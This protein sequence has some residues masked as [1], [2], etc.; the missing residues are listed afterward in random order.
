M[1]KGHTE[2]LQRRLAEIAACLST[3]EQMLANLR[4]ASSWDFLTEDLDV[5]REELIA[6][7]EAR[8]ARDERLQDTLGQ[9]LVG[10]A[11]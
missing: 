3:S 1:T 9:L 6:D 7:Y 2:L 11:Y 8:I 10:Q 4:D 5:N